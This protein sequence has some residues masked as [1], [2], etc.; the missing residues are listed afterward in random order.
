MG[1]WMKAI[2]IGMQI[3]TAVEMVKIGQPAELEVEWKDRRYKLVLSQ[4]RL[5]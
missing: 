4:K 3:L 5:T 2:S 1:K